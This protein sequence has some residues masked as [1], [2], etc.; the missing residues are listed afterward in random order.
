MAFNFAFLFEELMNWT[1]E[2]KNL[3]GF[4]VK[5]CI[6]NFY[7]DL[8][9]QIIRK[10]QGWFECFNTDEGKF[11]FSRSQEVRNERIPH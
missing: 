2:L 7:K 1:Y 10:F 8:L 11:C 6:E 4:Y 5:F 3:C 9:S